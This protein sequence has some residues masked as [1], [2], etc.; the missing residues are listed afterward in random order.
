MD[1]EN[2]HEN[3]EDEEAT[4]TKIISSCDASCG[5]ESDGIANASESFTSKR[6]FSESSSSDSVAVEE[7]RSELA[8]KRRRIEAVEPCEIEE[9]GTSGLDTEEANVE[10]ADVGQEAFS[11]NHSDGGRTLPSVFSPPEDFSTF[12]TL[13]LKADAERKP[14]QETVSLVLERHTPFPPEEMNVSCSV[15]NAETVLKCRRCGHSFSSCSALEEHVECGVEQEKKC[16]CCHCS[17]RAESSSSPHVHV[18]HTHGPQKIFSCD[19]CGF[20]CAEENLLNAHYLGKTHLRRQN[21]AARGGFVQ[22][23]TKQSFPKKSCVMGTKNVRTKPRA[24]KPLA[25]NGNSKG[26][27]NTGNNSQAFR[28]TLSEHSGGGSELLVEMMPS[29]NTSSGKEE[30]VEEN[31]TFG[32]VQNPENQ[33]KQLGGLVSSE[34]LLG[35]PESIQNTLQIAHIS[36]SAT[37]RT[38]SERNLLMLGNS[39]RR[40]PGTFTL[41]G[42]AKKRF[43][44]LGINKRGTNETQR[45]YMKHFRTQMKPND[46]Q[47][48]TEQRQMSQDVQSLCVTTS[49]DA[50]GTQDK[51]ASHLS[52]STQLG[53]LPV[54]PAPVCQVLCT[55]PE[56]GHIAADKTDLEIHVRRCPA[57]EMRFCCQTCNFSSPSR[58]DL[59]EHLHSNHHQ[60]VAPALSCQRCSFV[61][62]NEV[63]LRDHMKEKHN[64]GFF[65]TSCNLFLPEKDVE[66]HRATEM[67]NSLVVQPKMASSLSRDSVL[68]LS[69]L[70]SEN[71]EDS[72]EESG[73]AAK[74]DPAESRVSHGTEARHSSKPQFQCKKCFYKTRSSTVL[75][76]HIKLRHG[77]DYHFLCKACNLYSLSKEGMEKHI[78]RSK[79]LENAKKNNIGLSFEECI[80]RVCIGANDRKEESHVSGSGRAEGHV[81]VRLQEHSCREQS[82]LP[83][84][85]LPQSGVGTR[86]DELALA[87][88]PKRGRPK[89]SISR[90]CSHC[91]LLAS[92]ITNLT[93]HIRRKHS[94]QYSYLCKVCKYYTVTKGDMERHCATKK[95]KGRVEIEANGKQSSEII[96]GPEGGDLEACKKNSP[97]AVTASD[98]QADRS[99]ESA[100]SPT[101]KPVV[102]CGNAV[103][104]E[105]ENVFHSGDGEGSRRLSDRKGQFSLDPEDLLQQN[106]VCSQRDVAG[107]GDNRCLHCEFSAHSAASLEL[108]VKRKH[109]KEFEFYC[110]ACDY[111]AVTRREMTRH[112]ATEK[113][114]MKRQSYLNS[115]TVEAGSSEMSKSILVPEEGHSQNPE[116]FKIKP[117]Q[118]SDTVKP[119][120]AA[121]CSI[122]DENASLDMSRVLCAP[123]AVEIVTEEDHSFCE[124]LQQPLAK[125]K[126]MKPGEIVSLN[127]PSN[128]GSP[129]RLQAD[130]PGDYAADCESGKENHGLLNDASAGDPRTRCQGEGGSTSDSGGKVLD[131]P[132][133]SGD[134]DGDHSAESTSPAGDLDGGGQSKAGCESS[135]EDLKDVQADPVLE[136]K[137]ILMNS[138]HEIVL[139]EDGPASD[140]T[141]DSNDVYETIISIDDKGQ[142]M[143]SF[144]RFDSS[145]I[146]IKTSED[147][148]LVDQSEE[149]LLVAGVRVSELPTKDCVQ[150]LK[151]RK[152]EGSSFGESTRIRC[153]DCGFLADGLSG[154]NVHIAMKHP[155]KEKHFHCLLCGKSFYTE[156]NLHQH[157]ASAGHMRNEQASVEELPEGGATFKCV[158]CTEPFDSEQN[159]FLHIK[160]QHEELLREVN[161]YIVEDTEQ[162]NRERE[163]NQGN[164]CK[165]CGK[166]CRSSNSMA[167]LAHIRTHTGSKPF[168]CKICHFATAQL[169]DARNHVKRHLGMREYKCHV[170]GV[171]FVMKK[172]LNTHLLG[173]HGVGTPKER[174]FTCH[175]CDR[176]FTEKWALNNH[177]KL[178]T[179]EKPFKCTWPTCH[180]SFL[181]ASAMK[182]H[183]RTH[184]GEKS[185]L[186]DLCGF[187]GGTRHAL[188]K[189]RRQHTGEKPFKCD[190]CNFASTTQSH[191]TRHKRVHTGEKPYRCPWCDYR[192]NCAENIRKHILHTGKHE[193]VKMYNCPKCDY[194]TNVPVEFRNHLKEQHPDIENPDLAYLHAGIVSKSYECRLKGQ[195][196]TFV[197]TDSP[198]TAA[199]LVEESPVKEKSLRG[200]KRQASPPEQVQQVIIIQGYDGEFALDASVEETAAATLQTL[201]M[202]G[203]VARVVHIT[204]HGQVIATSQNGSHVGSVVPGPILPEQL[205]DGATQVV[206]MGGSVESPSV[207]E[208]LSPGGAVIQQVT[209]QEMLS[210]S[211]AAVP[212]A[213]TSS[214]LD[215]L[216]CAVTELGEV[217]HRAGHEEKGR[218]C[219]KD[220]LIQLPGQEPAH[221]HADTEAAETPLFQDG[222]ESPAAMEV[223]TQVV[224]PSAII[225]SQE[226]A[227]VAF[228]KM[229][230]GVLQF[231]VCDTGA[232]SQLMKDGVTQVIVNEEGAVHMVAAEGSQ[233]IMQDAETHGLRVPAEHVDLV[234]SEREISQIIVTEELVQAMVRESSSSFPEGATHYIVTELPPGVQEDTG[235]YS[236]TL[237]ETASA[238]EILQ[239]GAALGAEAVGTS[240]T[241][242]LTSM[243]IYTQDGS[244]AATVIQSQR[245]NSELQE[246]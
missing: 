143:Y 24:S 229:V 152:V 241:E 207:D 138:Q 113:H 236:H 7:E 21:L 220:V 157:L 190:E 227:Q 232:A 159:L 19:L 169:G 217:E 15:G 36:I 219:H 239:A 122:L 240:S 62:L 3:D 186:C 208:D 124:T 203:Q 80:E 155:T 77:Q 81:G 204:E 133:S 146:R 242:Q 6:G 235:V 108:H 58:E 41:K 211:E 14:A 94:H 102:D 30:V 127:T 96:V 153:D 135:A 145:I 136:N 12:D 225:T 218:P 173:K 8:S 194:G 176:S 43:N 44:L 119:R 206:V 87:P 149:G 22:I 111:Y 63:G 162:I 132:L 151:K 244:P 188:T 31:V 23:L 142:T 4:D 200:G 174:K 147:G 47:P 38:R 27:Q 52:G 78:K 167:F 65:C 230:Q 123:D 126:R 213:D 216:L 205:A 221:A 103:E 182:D 228:K 178:H 171:A 199:T 224:R 109:T 141:V 168:K 181:T 116:E 90:T 201:A 91:G 59:E 49:D 56:C 11:T 140:D 170:C 42:Q 106:D 79:H 164:I 184:T 74:E 223:L 54:K 2:K 209:K 233:F 51:T 112:A 165:Y 210:V 222:Q 25:R 85:E 192:S 179:G 89:G 86:D 40:R 130:N 66:E 118:S 158:K 114:K 39:F 156:S 134:L 191:L 10:S 243:V 214:A 128:H 180:Y 84:K 172:H 187:A 68:P 245:E 57:R 238:P 110:M 125:D 83:P 189:H 163:E 50:E 64:M 5:P 101:D 95:H 88:A 183:Y 73:K 48:M 93:V 107:S 117:D 35:K 226:R 129:G 100:A 154:L 29:R 198:F 33:N 237:I 76:R 9:Q 18:K 34:G 160:G 166:M 246:A 104:V 20:Q 70:E 231:A 212:A 28:G 150:G 61:S 148:E 144:G 1:S 215:A 120:N 202:A 115:S 99:A 234:E 175:L 82:L 69:N 71:M 46:A 137:E 139:E 98:E 195:G 92:S 193:G 67:H 60:Q 97:G 45:M 197:E 177:M 17:H 185:F 75:T 55:C 131:K 121:D 16:A 32:V 53:S 37:S 196:A 13:P 72:R 26:V 105:A 161:K